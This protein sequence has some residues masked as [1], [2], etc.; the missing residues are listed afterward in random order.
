MKAWSKTKPKAASDDN[1]AK[2]ESSAKGKDNDEQCKFSSDILTPCHPSNPKLCKCGTSIDNTV[3]SIPQ[4]SDWPVS[5]PSQSAVDYVS[6]L[7][8]SPK[9]I[10]STLS[11]IWGVDLH[12]RKTVT[13]KL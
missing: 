12:S 8:L 5:F 2:E 9:T 6:A 4:S 3:T 11:T 7:G 13:G 1:K 10:V